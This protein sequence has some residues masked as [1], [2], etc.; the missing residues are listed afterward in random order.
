M[1]EKKI[2]LLICTLIP[3]GKANKSKEQ[4]RISHVSILETIAETKNIR[5]SIFSLKSA[6]K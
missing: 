6:K 4:N 3:N 1:F 2:T 5:K